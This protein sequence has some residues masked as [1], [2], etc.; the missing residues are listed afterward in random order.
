M[1]MRGDLCS[2]GRGFE[3]QRVNWMD[4]SSRIIFVVKIVSMFDRKMGF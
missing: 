1:V 3:S 2:G 4:I